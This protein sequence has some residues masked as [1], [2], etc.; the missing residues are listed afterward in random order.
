[1]EKEKD[2]YTDS[3]PVDYMAQELSNPNYGAN[4]L[5]Q[6]AL[7]Q[8]ADVAQ[9]AYDKR[10]SQLAENTVAAD[11]SPTMRYDAYDAS[12]DYFNSEA[13]RYERQ[14]R[15]EERSDNVRAAALNAALNSFAGKKART[16]A[17]VSRANAFLTFLQNGP[18]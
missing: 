15:E 13:A 7:E 1:M 17:V 6:D 11:T 16:D 5:R 10:V 3:V 18:F 9:R 14:V 2:P 12:Y 4:A 8:A